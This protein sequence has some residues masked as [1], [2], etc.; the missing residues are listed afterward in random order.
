MDYKKYIALPMLRTMKSDEGKVFV[1]AR[2]LGGAALEIDVYKRYG[3]KELEDRWFF[4]Q[5][6]DRLHWIQYNV[7]TEKRTTR[8]PLLSGTWWYDNSISQRSLKEISAFFDRDRTLRDIHDEMRTI[9]ERKSIE[10]ATYIA[11]INRGIDSMPIPEGIEEWIHEK[12]ITNDRY[13]FYRRVK[14]YAYHPISDEKINNS[15]YNGYCTR[16]NQEFQFWEQPRHGES[17]YCP[18]CGESVKYRAEGISRK[19]LFHTANIAFT[20]AMLDGNFAIRCFHI[21][22]DYSGK[23]KNVAT[24]M[25]EFARYYFTPNRIWYSKNEEKW[26]M[27]NHL[28]PRNY[29]KL[30]KSFGI[31][32]GNYCFRT[33]GLAEVL[34]NSFLSKQSRTIM[35]MLQSTHYDGCEIEVLHS[36]AKYPV[37]EYIYKMGFVNLATTI[38]KYGVSKRADGI[39]LKGKTAE[40]VLGLPLAQ[41]K[42]FPNYKEFTVGKLQMARYLIKHNLTGIAHVVQDVPLYTLQTLE[43]LTDVVSVDK[44]VKYLRKQD[45]NASISLKIADYCDYIK[46]CKELEYDLADRQILFPPHLGEAHA[47]SILARK[48]KQISAQK[49]GFCKSI[50][51]W[52]KKGYSDGVFSI[53]VIPTPEDLI[54]EA[55]AM[56]NCSA[57]Y[58]NSIAEGRCSIWTIRECFAPDTAFYMLELSKDGRVIQCRGVATGGGYGGQPPATPEVQAFVDKWLKKKINKKIRQTVKVKVAV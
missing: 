42:Q 23:Y 31:F 21:D 11:E 44:A 54:R 51:K 22:R 35:D 41:L 9:L 36:F 15:H 49:E 26:G 7:N 16:C 3:N 17:T 46:D 8:L 48:F 52:L 10:N 34:Q 20:Q 25:K 32:D 33:E 27:G 56:H 12:V 30:E 2:I 19:Q 43:K 13:L 40:E 1:A 24:C 4:E 53:A 5:G 47:R 6:E 38:T 18:M 55:Q 50:A 14:E 39:N 28:Y 45:Y 29:F 57:G 37:I 58:C